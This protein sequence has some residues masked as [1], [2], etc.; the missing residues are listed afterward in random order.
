MFFSA[1]KVLFVCKMGAFFPL[2]LA[3]KMGFF[4]LGRVLFKSAFFAKVHYDPWICLLL[5][6]L[7]LCLDCR[8]AF[9]VFIANNVPPTETKGRNRL[10]KVGETACAFW[11]ILLTTSSYCTFAFARAKATTLLCV[12]ANLRPVHTALLRLHVQK[13]QHFYVFVPSQINW[14]CTHFSIKRITST[15]SLQTFSVNRH[16]D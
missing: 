9:C 5:W 12:R 8:F 10:V 11:S 4:P 16:L 7:L 15:L 1:P 14:Y 6:I 2:C 13:Q 3:L